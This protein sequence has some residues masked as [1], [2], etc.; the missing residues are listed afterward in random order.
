MSSDTTRRPQRG[1]WKTLLL[2]KTVNLRSVNLPWHQIHG[3]AGARFIHNVPAW[4]VAYSYRD[5]I[6]IY[7]HTIHLQNRLR[8]MRF[9]CKL[10]IR[11]TLWINRLLKLQ[12][13]LRNF[14]VRVIAQSQYPSFTSH[15]GLSWAICDQTDIFDGAVAF[16]DFLQLLFCTWEWEPR[17]EDLL[18]LHGR[19]V[20]KHLQGQQSF[21]CAEQKW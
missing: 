7:H 14:V 17:D 20:L 4:R 8:S 11:Q 10:N 18:F 19:V 2:K 13:M 5:F 15:L 21:Y 16:A 9:L 1:G 3:P 12:T 6:A